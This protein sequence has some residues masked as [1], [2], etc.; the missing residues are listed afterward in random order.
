MTD[1]ATRIVIRH[2]SGSKVNQIDQFDLGG[3]EE[4]TFGRDPSSN[5]QYDFQRDDEVSRRHAVIRVKNDNELY[6]LIADLNSSNGTFLNGERI[7]GEVELLPND[8]IELGTGGPK[9]VFDVQPRPA[10]MPSRTPQTGAIDLAATRVVGPAVPVAATVEHA[11]ASDTR[12]RGAAGEPPPVPK[13]SVG[14]ATIQ[15][16]LFEERRSTRQ[17]WIAALAAVLVLALLGGG[18]LYWHNQNVAESLRQEVANQSARTET[19]KRDFENELT[20]QMGLTS[21]DI[22]RLGDAT[23]YIHNQWQLYDRD[24]NRPIFQKMA[25]VDGEWL[26]CYVKMDDGRLVRWLTL[27]ND[28]DSFYKPVGKDHSGSGFVISEQGFIL[29]NKH[30][31]AGWTSEYED[32]NYYSW[33]RGSVYNANKSADRHQTEKNVHMVRSLTDWVPESGGYLFESNRPVPISSGQREFFGRNEVLTIQF[34]GTRID[35][36]ANLV[37]TSIDADVAEIKIDATQSLSKLALADDKSV[38]VGDTIFLLGYPG[39]S[40]ETIAVQQSSEGGRV[41]NRSVYIPEPT[42]TKGIVAKMPTK[43]KKDQ[44]DVTTYGTT[45]DTYQLDIF[46]GPGHSGG[47]VLDATGKVIALLSLVSTT[48]QHVSFAVPVSYVRE[49]LQPQRNASP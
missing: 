10:N 29:T 12:Q 2:L 39:V 43:T 14:K 49:L 42:V 9:F 25:K 41:R 36:N 18:A 11:S 20:K 7:G 21:S 3:L 23:V 37:R 38:Q 27:E 1:S 8:V 4:I 46:A 48:A 35:I 40:Q 16:M 13:V 32:F 17:V 34:P 30:V 15:R 6:F 44:G 28:K 19:V 5:V 33:T 24:T 47:P 26:P 22:S 31:A 45:G